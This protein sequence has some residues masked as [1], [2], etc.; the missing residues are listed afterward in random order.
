MDE[1]DGTDIDPTRRLADQQQVGV[2]LDLAGDHD[3]LLVAAREIL[4]RQIRV[5]RAH[6]ETLDLAHGVG[7]D[8]GIVHHQPVLEFGRVVIAEGHVFPG[9]EIHDQPLDL[10]VLGDMADAGMTPR[11]CVRAF[12]GQGLALQ[13]NLAGKLRAG[14]GIAAQY[15]QQLRLAVSGDAGDADDLAGADVQIDAAQPLDAVGIDHAQAAHLQHRG[16]GPGGGLV[17]AQQH[18]AP[19][20]QLGQ[21]GGVRLGGFDRGHHL[22]AP[23]DRNI[24][25]DLHDL[26]QLVGD[27]DDGF[28]FVPQPAQDAK[29]VIGLG[30]GQNARGLVQDQDIG[31]T[32]KR[33]QDL[34][35]LLVADRQLFDQGVRIDLQFVFLGQPLQL[36]PRTRERGAQHRPVLGAKDDVFQNGEILHQLE[37]LKHHADAGADRGLAVGDGDG[38]A[39]DQD[40]AGIGAVKT[41][42][43]R[44]QRRFSGAILADNAVDG[45]ARH[46]QIDA[47]VGLNRPEC[48]GN[49]PQ[50]DCGG[51]VFSAGACRHYC[52]GQVLS[53]M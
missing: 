28:A 38:L 35:P 52:T 31:L 11:P 26:A 45:A 13:R 36:G 48:L 1:F 7:A 2:A 18:L 29:Q 12:Q 8:R 42:K 25:G 10:T 47:L 40:L 9:G 3:L 4:G 5:R 32:V 14:F 19:D 15:L 53:V 21:R 30:R 44:H 33:L 17:D 34:D 22:A 37:M 23:H 6:V 27:Q 46:R 39:A 16:A 41:I 49:P 24:V 50:F 51:H 20:H 43:D